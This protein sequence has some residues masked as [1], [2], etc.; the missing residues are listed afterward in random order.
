LG[1]EL[2]RI[3]NAFLRGQIIIF[4]LAGLTYVVVLSI[5]GLHYALAIALLAGLARFV[6]WVGNMVSW[7]TLALVAY[8]Q[9][10]NVFGMA[11]LYYAIL[12]VGIAL[13]VDQIFDNFVT[14]RVIAQAL[15]VHPA[16]VLIAALIFAKLLGLLGVLVAAPI[17]ATV[18]LVWRYV[19][20]KMLDLDPW[21]EGAGV[22]LA[23]PPSR[24]WVH[25]RR[26]LRS[27]KPGQ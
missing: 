26:L 4:L 6:P 15:R 1:Q 19:T 14:P 2:S 24:L 16:A 7:T 20:R 13:L 18:A 9:P 17:L 23:P 10:T 3:W 5:L 25:L 12:A 11:P 27:R 8:F 22:P 21:P